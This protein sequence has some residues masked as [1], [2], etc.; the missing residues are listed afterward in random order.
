MHEDCSQFIGTKDQCIQM[1]ENL[2][3]DVYYTSNGETGRPQ[4]KLV[5]IESQFGKVL[6]ERYHSW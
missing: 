3:T 6:K 4:Y 2:N 5:G 1:I